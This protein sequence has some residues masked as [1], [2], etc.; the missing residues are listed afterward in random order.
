M[1][2]NRVSETV[3][4][5]APFLEILKSMAPF[6]KTTQKLPLKIPKTFF[7]IS[8]ATQECKV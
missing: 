1:L 7:F 6:N 4:Q 5:M 2:Q 8:S 3:F